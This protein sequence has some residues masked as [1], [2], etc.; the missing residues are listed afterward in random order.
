[1]VGTGYQD[2]QLDGM[3]ANSIPPWGLLAVPVRLSVRD[4]QHNPYCSGSPDPQLS[5]VLHEEWAHEDILDA[6]P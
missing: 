4:P 6:L 2:L 3:L 1:V 5:R